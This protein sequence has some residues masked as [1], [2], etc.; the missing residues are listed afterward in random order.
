MVAF[1]CHSL[2]SNYDGSSMD[3]QEQR[4]NALAKLQQFRAAA[5]GE[6]D[7]AADEVARVLAEQRRSKARNRLIGAGKVD[8]VNWH[9]N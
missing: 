4:D 6:I 8:I 1:I 5:A 2:E 9:S 3:D 7:P